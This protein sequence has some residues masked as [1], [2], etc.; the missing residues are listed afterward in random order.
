MTYLP[1]VVRPDQDKLQA[2]HMR[3]VR[4]RRAQLEFAALLLAVR[5]TYILRYVS[6]FGNAPIPGWLSYRSMLVAM[7]SLYHT[8]LLSEI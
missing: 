5:C 2:R 3:Q 4:S 1:P 6:Q 7:R 8:V